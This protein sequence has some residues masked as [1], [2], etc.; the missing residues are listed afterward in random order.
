VAVH[1]WNIDNH[2]REL[3]CGRH[4][5]GNDLVIADDYVIH[6]AFRAR[7]LATQSLGPST[8][9]EIRLSLSRKVAQE[10]WTGLDTH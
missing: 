5:A 1:H 6:G 9:L 2:S 8:E 7:E 10:C 3:L 4:E